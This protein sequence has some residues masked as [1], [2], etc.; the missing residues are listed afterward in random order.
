MKAQMDVAVNEL[1]KR[2]NRLVSLRARSSP[3]M[4]SLGG[5]AIG[6]ILIYAGWASAT[7][8]QTP[9]NFI[10]F[11]T[12]FLFAYEPAKRLARLQLNLESSI[13]GVRMM[14]EIMDTPAAAT[15]TKGEFILHKTDGNLT[16]KK[17]GFGYR[18]DLPVLHDL[19]LVIR[20]NSKTA[21]VGPSGGGKSTIFALLQRFYDVNEGV[22]TIDGH[23][24]RNLNTVSLRDHIAFV[25]QDTYLFSGTISDNIRIGRLNATDAEIELA[26]KDAY[27]HEFIS[28]LPQGYQTNVGENGAQLSGGQRQRIA[29]AR[30]MLKAAPILLL[31][32][33]TSALDSQSEQ[34]V[35]MAFD[36]LMEGRTTIVIAHRLST[37]VNADQIIVIDNGQIIEK[38]THADLLA[39][40]SLYSRLYDH[41]F[42]DETPPVC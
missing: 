32:E 34:V 11:L 29:I 19:N 40:Q 9:G 31:D 28:E 7:S 38:G 27:A 30:A 17:V 4:E 2:A 12:A 35:Q 14:F 6:M 33:A 18:P 26:A 8:G 15:E 10:A 22:I 1:E 37:V 20:S 21:L 41:Q 16:F 23:D 24:I 42:K 13:F 36:R 25:S 5:I 39:K 3:L